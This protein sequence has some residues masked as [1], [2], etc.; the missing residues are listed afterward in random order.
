MCN[1]G[2]PQTDPLEIKSIEISP[3]PP[4]PGE[5]LTVKVVGEA[6]EKVEVSVSALLRLF[7]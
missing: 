3:D 4:K 6:R 7:R 2:D 1:V 5:E